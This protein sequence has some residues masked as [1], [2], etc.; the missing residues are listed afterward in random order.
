MEFRQVYEYY[1]RGDVQEALLALAR[2]RE[3][4]GVFKTGSFG[5][6]PG[7][8]V[9]ANDIISQVKAG[10][11]EFHSSIERWSNPMSIRPDNHGK[12]R[13]GWDLILDIDCDS[14]EHGRA[15]AVVLLDALEKHGIKNAS[16]KFTGGTGFH[17]GVPWES[18]PKAIDYAPTEKLF[19]DVAR[20]MGLYLKEYCREEME[21]ALLRKFLPGDMAKAVNMPLEKIT[22]DTGIDPYKIVDIDPIL[23]S[24]RHLFRMA[25]SLNRNT[26][27]VSLP[28]ARKDVGGFRKGM[29]EPDVAK[30]RLKFLGEADPGEAEVLVT[31]TLDWARKLG[32][33]EKKRRLFEVR[34]REI[35][36]PIGQAY[37]PPCVQRISQGLADG[38]KRS[39]FIMINFLRSLKWGWEE[40]EK[41]V[42]EWNERN[43]PPLPHNYIMSQIRSGRTRQSVL[44]PNCLNEGYYPHFGVCM[45]DSL[46]TGGGQAIVIKNPVN[47][48][49]KKFFAGKPKGEKG[50]IKRRNKR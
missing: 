21:K 49:K 33:A 29:A 10:V 4:A 16:V 23:I 46:C 50:D 6:R 34:D 20:K 5:A 32:D 8:L 3:V 13:V 40:I 44:P 39:V 14:V 42:V 27:L 2:S 19:P 45:P 48:S 37:F 43:T 47:Y 11:I 30:V 38:R 1:S 31:E 17:L 9:Y 26:G 25:Y 18:M 24:P 15:A 41:Y 28:I 36:S 35:R 22:T 7:M 12:L